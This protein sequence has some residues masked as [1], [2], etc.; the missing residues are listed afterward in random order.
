M[1]KWDWHNINILWVMLLSAITLGLWG[2]GKT[3]F[4]FFWFTPWLYLAQAAGVAAITTLSMAFIY[5]TRLRFLRKVFGE[6]QHVYRIHMVNSVSGI[7]L[8]VLHFL[9]FMIHSISYPTLFKYYLVPTTDLTLDYGRIAF[10]VF[11]LLVIVTY[12]KK[13]PYHIWK[14]THKFMGV[15]LLFALLHVVTV[16][17]DVRFNKPLRYWII[18]TMAIGVTSCLYT[19]FLYRYFGPKRKYKVTSVKQINE[20]VYSINMKP[21]NK[22]IKYDPA[23]FVFLSFH[24]SKIGKEIHPFTLSSIEQEDEIQISYKELGDY[25]SKLK[26]V[27]VGTEVDVWGP[28]GTFSEKFLLDKRD[29]VWIA[30][31]I[32]VTPFISML[33]HQNIY[34]LQAKKWMLYCTYSAE[35]AP[36]HEHL[37]DQANKHEL[38]Y[39]HHKANE[40]GFLNI[41]YLSSRIPDFKEKV[42]MLCGPPLMMKSLEK[43]LHK[44][45]VTYHRVI[46]EDFTFR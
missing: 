31:G 26:D 17:S 35:D 33:K 2:Y 30:G 42:F 19:L 34:D 36:Y 22:P 13:I 46:H 7:V 12:I 43:A 44:A 27:E 37:L 18:F 24:S 41:E 45:G 10:L 23:Q 32:G 15:A 11:I 5:T 21:V 39:F 25:T 8:I 40:S 14:L 38:E 9:F 6:L 28:Y 4:A 3:S 16:T 20:C 1:P 29:Q